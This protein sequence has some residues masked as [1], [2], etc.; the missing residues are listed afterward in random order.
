M[1]FLTKVLTI[2]LLVFLFIFQG[3]LLA[4]QNQRPIEITHKKGVYKYN[5][6]KLSPKQLME[7]TESNPAAYRQMKKAKNH[8]DLATIFGT[9]GGGVVGWAIGSSI[10]GNEL[11]FDLLT[12]GGIFIACSIPFIIDYKNRSKI[13]VEHYNSRLNMSEYKTIGYRLAFTGNG[14][15]LVVSF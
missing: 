12:V 10:S 14:L 2:G 9:I 6:S 3:E 5:N 15:G 4:Q 1:T 11:S 7:L 13:A 8:Y